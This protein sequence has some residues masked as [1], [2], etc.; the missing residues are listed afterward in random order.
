MT[1]SCCYL[2]FRIIC[3][4]R[5]V[6]CYSS[7]FWRFLP[8]HVHCG[9]SQQEMSSRLEANLQA[10]DQSSRPRPRLPPARQQLKPPPD[11]L[12][13][14]ASLRELS[15]RV[16]APP[17]A[18]VAASTRP[19]PAPGVSSTNGRSGSRAGPAASSLAHPAATSATPTAAAFSP[20]CSYRSTQ[21]QLPLRARSSFYSAGSVK[22]HEQ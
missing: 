3:S 2:L 22:K 11:F 1:H 14:S 9:Q 17:R 10:F 16:V 21:K 19:P 4:Q 8:V 13:Q 5:S 18:A 6:E 7:Q 20:S 12:L 15:A